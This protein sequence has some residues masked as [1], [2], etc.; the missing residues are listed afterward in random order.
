MFNAVF[1]A[2]ASVCVARLLR[3]RVEVGAAW[4]IGVG[5]VTAVSLP[6]LI[7]DNL[8]LSELCFLAIALALLLALERLVDGPAPA[9]RVLT[10]GAAIGACALVRTHGVVLVPAVVIALGVRRRRCSPQPRWRY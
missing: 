2:I 3:T 4:S 8:V 1:L 9:W 6:L 5:A 7:L 10:L